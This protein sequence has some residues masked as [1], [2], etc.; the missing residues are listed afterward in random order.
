[1]SQRQHGELVKWKG[2]YGFLKPDDGGK[3]VFVS[4]GEMTR[5]G[6]PEPVEGDRYTWM[7]TEAD[8]GRLRAT[9]V[10]TEGAQRAAERVFH[11]PVRP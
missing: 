3:D 7:V 4:V 9:D 10:R 1:M 8:D 6:S 5:A 2:G 11:D